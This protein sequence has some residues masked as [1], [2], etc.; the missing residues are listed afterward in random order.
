M[1][2]NT[3]PASCPVSHIAHIQSHTPPLCLPSS[4]W[5]SGVISSSQLLLWRTTDWT[6]SCRGLQQHFTA[7]SHL[8]RGASGNWSEDKTYGFTSPQRM[9]TE[10]DSSSKICQR[11]YI[12]LAYL[13]TEMET[14]WLQTF[15]LFC[16]HRQSQF[17]C[18]KKSFRQES[19]LWS[20]CKRRTALMKCVDHRNLKRGKES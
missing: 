8:Q 14:K 17:M 3:I 5:H 7:I 4:S 2:L 1:G 6:S 15:N 19:R 11:S 9:N 20:R 18:V 12:S 10:Y 16:Q 13:N